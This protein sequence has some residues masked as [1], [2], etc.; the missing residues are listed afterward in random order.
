MR[1]SNRC[2]CLHD[3]CSP[4]PPRKARKARNT[5]TYTHTPSYENI[6]QIRCLYE[7]V[8]VEDML[9]NWHSGMLESY[10][11]KWQLDRCVCIF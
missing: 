3:G 4:A 8:G 7:G 5:H 10:M 9:D 6:V 1:I 2:H 11:K